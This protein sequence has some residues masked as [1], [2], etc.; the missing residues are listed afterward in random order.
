MP[1]SSLFHSHIIVLSR[2]GPEVG[3]E[4]E[5]YARPESHM[6]FI[7][8]G[9][10]MDEYA[11]DEYGRPITPYGQPM[12]GP[13]RDSTRTRRMTTLIC[14]ATVDLGSEEHLLMTSCMDILSPVMENTV[15]FCNFCKD[16]PLAKINAT[17][18][19]VTC[20]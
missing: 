15:N 3:D 16:G 5:P 18:M 2:Y 6:G 10:P 14:T 8:Q 1:E 17:Y 4:Y 13:V 12:M 19:S 7:N 20:F 9:D 11:V